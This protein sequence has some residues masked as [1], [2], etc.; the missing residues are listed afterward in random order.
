MGRGSIPNQILIAALAITSTLLAVCFVS[1]CDINTA[2]TQVSV[3]SASRILQYV[4]T[5]R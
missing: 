3:L 4:K 1:K 2:H 5:L